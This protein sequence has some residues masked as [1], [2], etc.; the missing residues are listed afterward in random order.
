[1]VARVSNKGASTALK[2]PPSR[3]T[4]GFYDIDPA[5]REAALLSLPALHVLTLRA[6]VTQQFVGRAP[7][8][9]RTD[10]YYSG[11]PSSDPKKAPLFVPPDSKLDAALQNDLKHGFILS[12]ND[13]VTINPETVFDFDSRITIALSPDGNLVCPVA[14]RLRGRA[15]LWDALNADHTPYFEERHTKED[16]FATWQAGFDEGAYLPLVLSASFDVPLRAL[17]EEQKKVYE[18]AQALARTVFIGRGSATFR[19]APYGSLKT[20]LLDLFKVDHTATQRHNAAPPPV[21]P[22]GQSAT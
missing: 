2:G 12:G 5:E 3:Q 9:Y 6:G 19:D 20:I 4:S 1:M 22:H 16:V 18:R 15:Q 14:G 10:L 13:W 21:A 7:G 11:E 8:G 17:D